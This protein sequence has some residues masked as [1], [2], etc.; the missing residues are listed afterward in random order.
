MTR[1]RPLL[2]EFVNGLVERDVVSTK[3]KEEMMKANS[4]GDMRSCLKV[5]NANLVKQCARQAGTDSSTNAQWSRSRE[6]LDACVVPEQ[7]IYCLLCSEKIAFQLRVVTSEWVASRY[8]WICRIGSMLGFVRLYKGT[9][10]LEWTPSS[11]FLSELRGGSYAVFS[12]T[13]CKKS[14]VLSMSTGVAATHRVD[15]ESVDSD[16]DS[17]EFND[18]THED[19][20]VGSC[21][22]SGPVHGCLG[23]SDVATI[24]GDLSSSQNMRQSACPPLLRLQVQLVVPEYYRIVNRVHY[25][26]PCKYDVSLRKLRDL[27]GCSQAV[28]ALILKANDVSGSL[29]KLLPEKSASIWAEIDLCPVEAQNLGI[30]IFLLTSTLI[31]RVVKECLSDIPLGAR[32]SEQQQDIDIASELLLGKNSFLGSQM[33]EGLIAGVLSGRMKLLDEINAYAADIVPVVASLYN[34][35]DVELDEHGFLTCQLPAVFFRGGELLEAPWRQ[36]ATVSHN[37]TSNP[38]C[39]S[40]VGASGKMVLHCGPADLPIQISSYVF[41][42]PLLKRETVMS[43]WNQLLM[44]LGAGNQDRCTVKVDRG[45]AATASCIT[46]TLWYQS[47]QQLLDTAPSRLRGKPGERP[48]M[49][50]FRGE[51]ATDFGGPFHEF[52]SCL[53]KEIMGHLADNVDTT[54]PMYSACIPCPN[55]THAIGPNQDT[56]VLSPFSS[57]HVVDSCVSL[58]DS[59]NIA[60][61]S[62]SSV[63]PSS[64]VHD[65][66]AKAS[67][68]A[69]LPTLAAQFETLTPLLIQVNEASNIREESLQARDGRRHQPPGRLHRT[70]DDSVN[71]GKPAGAATKSGKLDAATLA[72]VELGMFEL[73]GRTMAMCVTTATPLNVCLNS[74]IWKKLV[75]SPISLQD[76]RDSDCVAVEMLWSLRLLASEGPD[77]WDQQVGS[78]RT[79]RTRNLHCFVLCC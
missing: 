7:M 72:R 34:Q 22:S 75:G 70:N 26:W 60:A 47:T 58:A 15:C 19:V 20:D 74:I 32:H 42:K 64:N 3:L 30:N 50:V 14:R 12:N 46:Q 4:L 51:G 55:S 63:S 17:C 35:T 62:Q 73:L 8:W 37:E 41:M 77:A 56:V 27:C 24:I 61:C 57:P 53:S 33:H 59:C 6:I 44:L 1:V 48:F 49:V 23:G 69:G 13:G 67:C 43:L 29:N 9:S 21:V 5:L 71:N 39:S 2:R 36:S 68:N 16:F 52:I 11:S 25:Q 66:G 54:K 38:L 65:D 76:L 40:R 78:P 79:L 10:G 45:L 31:H 18:H 28:I